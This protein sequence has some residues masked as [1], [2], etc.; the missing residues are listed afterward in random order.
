[1]FCCVFRK[2]GSS[3]DAA[4]ERSGIEEEVKEDGESQIS[5]AHGL[6]SNYGWGRNEEATVRIG[7]RLMGG[8]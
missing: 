2:K 8:G 5:T 3:D 7:S 1:V 4:D 6:N